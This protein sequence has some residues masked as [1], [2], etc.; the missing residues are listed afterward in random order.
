MTLPP[1]SSG[2]IVGIGE[3]RLGR[4]PGVESVQLQAA[5]CVAAVADA[6][7]SRADVDGLI[8]L[9]PYSNPS[10][11]FAAALGEYL[12]LR[13]TVELAI[14]SGGIVSPMMMLLHAIAMIDAGQCTTVVCS[15]GDAAYSGRRVEGSGMTTT[16]DAVAFEAA[17]GLVGTVIPYALLANRRM[18]QF[19]TTPEDLGAIAISARTHAV[20]RENSAQRAPFTLSE[21][22]ASPVV[23][24][25][26]RRLDCS[27]IVDGAGAFVVTS[28][29][30]ASGLRHPPVSV[31]GFA[32]HASHRNV[33]QFPDFDDLRLA[34][35][36][37][38]A[39][40][41]AGVGLD[42][43]DVAQIHDAFTISTAIYLEDLGFCGRGE[44]GEYVRA[45]HLDLGGRCPTNTHGGLLSQGHVGG[46]LQVTEAVTQLRGDAGP[47]QVEGAEIAMLAGGG[48]IMGI[49]AVMILARG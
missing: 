33:S 46:M 24:T 17:F 49:N 21:Y 36:G 14:D 32:S 27:T 47:G 45:G 16:G 30:R 38:R 13:P 12:G 15:F 37:R 29:E 5:A 19:G 2:A 42:D 43:V 18:Q 23:S 48:G 41:Q 8:A 35:I 31:R 39:L 10:M 11:V 20:R 4:S 22:M 40:G 7:L 25:P 34:Q 9:C 6:G 26:L 1:F 3:T 28:N 44:V